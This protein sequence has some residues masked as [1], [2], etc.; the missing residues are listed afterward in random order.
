ML[1][2]KLQAMGINSFRQVADFTPADIQRITETLN[3]R[4]RVDQWVEQARALAGK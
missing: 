3:V 1:A 2:K 4:G